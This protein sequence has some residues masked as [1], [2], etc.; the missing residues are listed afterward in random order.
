L[1]RINAVIAVGNSNIEHGIQIRL[2]TR[3]FSARGINPMRRREFITLLGGVTVVWPLMAGAQQS[4]RVRR[5]GVM[6]SGP[7]EADAEGQARVAALKLGLL[8]RGWI[9]GRNLKIDYRWPGADTGRMRVYAAELVGLKPD[10]IFAAPTAALAEVQRATRTIP[11]VFV[12][13]SDPVGAG[14]VASLAH[15]GG[16]ITGFAL[17]NLALAQNGW[18]CSSRSLL[19]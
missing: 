5:L 4:D 11:V 6:V 15:P 13:V 2:A 1:I 16:N 3:W 18:N 17:S 8:E 14:F 10:V 12:Q 7:T 19:L 9:E